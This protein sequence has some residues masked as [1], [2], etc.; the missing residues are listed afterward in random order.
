MWSYQWKTTKNCEHVTNCL[1]PMIF[2]PKKIYNVHIYIKAGQCTV[3]WVFL[4]FMLITM[5]IDRFNVVNLNSFVD[6]NTLYLVP[7]PQN[8]LNSDPELSCLL[9]LH[10]QFG[11]GTKLFVMV[12]LS[13]RTR[14]QAVCYGYIIIFKKKQ[15]SI[16]FYFKNN[17][18]RRKFW[19]KTVIFCQSGAWVPFSVSNCVEL[20]LYSE[21]GSWSDPTVGW[22]WIQFGSGFTTRIE[23]N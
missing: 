6:T 21:Y 1:F 19:I 5:F 18:T 8:C 15:L 7:D 12:T 10:Y 3:H 20:D 17:G 23:T 11:S 4:K 16:F 9:W 22:I 13:I 14:N 2:S